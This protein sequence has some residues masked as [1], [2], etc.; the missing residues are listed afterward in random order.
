M[1]TVRTILTVYAIFAG[2]GSALVLVAAFRIGQI[3]DRRER[4][5]E[6]RRADNRPM[7]RSVS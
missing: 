1:N 7:L 6:H 5:I 4:D 3:R 2:I